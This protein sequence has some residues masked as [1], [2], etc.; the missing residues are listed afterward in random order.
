MHKASTTTSRT[1]PKERTAVG[2][3][4]SLEKE[5][6][7]RQ[8]R[9]NA[10]VE[11]TV[12]QTTEVISKTYDKKFE[13]FESQIADNIAT[14]IPSTPVAVLKPIGP[15]PNSPPPGLSQGAPPVP[16]LLSP[17]DQARRAQLL[18][19]VARIEGKTVD[20]ERL[21]QSAQAFYA[22][23]GLVPPPLPGA[24]VGPGFS[25]SHAQ[26]LQGPRFPGLV[27][28]SSELRRP[29]RLIEQ[30]AA[31]YHVGADLFKQ[32]EYSKLDLIESYDDLNPGARAELEALYPVVARFEDVI[33]W[34]ESELGNPN[35][36][37]QDGV[38]CCLTDMHATRGCIGCLCYIPTAS[39]S[40]S[41]RHRDHR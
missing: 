37:A 28:F 16:K 1:T 34:Y 8:V 26:T 13:L 9:I 17:T 33:Q 11:A 18:A 10:T 19:E 20:A 15:P 40:A 41:S 21:D 6:D 35:F 32:L 2:S 7:K 36:C 23:Q 14:A 22:A 38:Y 30:D 31:G 5:E 39:T 29:A 27:H 24:P 4:S 25:Q 12:A 3:A